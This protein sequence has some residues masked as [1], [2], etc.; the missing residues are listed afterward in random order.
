[1][2]WQLQSTV[3]FSFIF[4][5]KRTFQ[6]PAKKVEQSHGKKIEQYKIWSLKTK[7]LKANR[8]CVCPLFHARLERVS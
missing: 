4:L 5:P 2:P 8:K 7:V 3:L 6:M 1:M